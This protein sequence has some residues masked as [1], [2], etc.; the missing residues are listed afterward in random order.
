MVK[1]T[2]RMLTP[3]EVLQEGLSLSDTC[4]VPE[5]AASAR[6]SLQAALPGA[7]AQEARLAQV[8]DFFLYMPRL[9]ARTSTKACAMEM[10]SSAMC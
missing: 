10:W 7:R 5:A 3:M 2:N 6:A 4:S 8:H 1:A 9:M